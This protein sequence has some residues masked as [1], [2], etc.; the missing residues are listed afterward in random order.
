MWR[1]GVRIRHALRGTLAAA[2]AAC[3]IL[4]PTA[5]SA[6]HDKAGATGSTTTATTATSTTVADAAAT[7]TLPA[8][9]AARGSDIDGATA[10]A[11]AADLEGL[12]AAV[13]TYEVLESHEPT[14]ASAL[15]SAG[16][17]REAPKWYAVAPSPDGTSAR[18]SLTPTGTKDRCPPP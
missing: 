18:Y 10:A 7:P 13:S 17:L 4:S 16:R 2:L 15:V 12:Q 5:C 3:A 6:H 1:P 9:A 14:S 8:D 11:C